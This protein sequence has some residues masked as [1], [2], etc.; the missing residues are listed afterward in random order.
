MMDRY[1]DAPL[2][3]PG[4]ANF[5]DFRKDSG[6]RRQNLHRLRVARFLALLFIELG[7][8]AGAAWFLI[9]NLMTNP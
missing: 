7:A 5:P 8:V 3:T 4:D 1:Q 2:A 9:S 6:R